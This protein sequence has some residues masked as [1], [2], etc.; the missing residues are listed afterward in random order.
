MTGTWEDYVQMPAD[1]QSALGYGRPVYEVCACQC[2][3]CGF[4]AGNAMPSETNYD[5]WRQ[6]TV[7][8][9]VPQGWWPNTRQQRMLLDQAIAAHLGIPNTDASC[10]RQEIEDMNRVTACHNCNSLTSRYPTQARQG[11]VLEFWKAA[12]GSAPGAAWK[13]R[14]RLTLDWSI[15]SASPPEGSGQARMSREGWLEGIAN[16][17]WEVWLAKCRIARGKIRYQRQGY[18]KVAEYVGLEV[19]QDRREGVAPGELDSRAKEII[20]ES[21]IHGRNTELQR[22]ATRLQKQGHAR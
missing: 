17:L 9:I 2:L 20:F 15:L 6:L 21:K 18:S 22:I 14:G 4:G 10:L 11:P 3:Y 12:I 1:P 16:A 5:I 8:H 13:P 7:E 19:L